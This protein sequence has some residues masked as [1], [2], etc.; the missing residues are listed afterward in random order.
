M[1]ASATRPRIGQVLLA[2]VTPLASI[3]GSGF[4]IIVPALERTV[5]PWSGLAIAGVCLVAWWIGTSIRHVIRVV[6]PLAASGNL[7]ATS[8]RID[9]ASDA[10][11]VVAYVISVALY[12]RIMAQYVVDYFVP[13]GSSPA[14]RVIACVAVVLI[15]LVGVFRGFGG[16]DLLDRL[17]LGAVLVLVTGL[18]ATLLWHDIGLVQ[19]QAL[20]L[21]PVPDMGLGQVLLV[22]GG[23]L[24]TVQGFETVRY[25]GEEYD[26]P[27]RIWAS[28]LAQGIA[29]IVYVGFVLLATPVM[30]IGT[31]RGPDQTLLDITMRVTPL[32]TLPLLLAAG[33]S[34]LSAAVADT[35]AADGN[36]RNLWS[37]MAGPRPFIVSGVAAV[38]L[39]ASIPTFTIIAVASRAFAAYYAL[40]AVLAL[41]TSQELLPKLGYGALAAALVAV[42]ALAAPVA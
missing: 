27:T 16:L 13:G 28:R 39:A 30:G 12:L 11:I 40:Q 10:V 22:L 18:G 19:S 17:A 8:R 20:R 2:V 25:L 5:G 41:R 7:D 14:E 34:Q 24:I 15:V 26:G 4:L 31:P 32:L 3:F 21:P 35:A 9:T 38:A 42:T 36:L 1:S 6:E 37:W 33:L 23:I 29:A